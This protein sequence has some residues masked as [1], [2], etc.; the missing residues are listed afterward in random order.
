MELSLKKI[1]GIETLH[2]G[3]YPCICPFQ[4]RI[5]VPGRMAGTADINQPTCNELCPHFNVFE[6]SSNA[7]PGKKFVHTCMNEI[8]ARD[9]RSESHPLFNG[10]SS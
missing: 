1:N 6:N 9:L 5:L 8:Q 7:D 10:K 2:R 4:S 3:D